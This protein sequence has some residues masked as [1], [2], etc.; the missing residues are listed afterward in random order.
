MVYRTER[1]RPM[2][3]TE[4]L[5]QKVYSLIEDW[6]SDSKSKSR[7]AE[8]ELISICEPIVK[9]FYKIAEQFGD[10]KVVGSFPYEY[11]VDRG[12]FFEVTDFTGN[13]I[14]FHYRDSCLGEY[15]E[16]YLEMPLYW[17]K[18]GADEEYFNECKER[19]VDK[20]ELELKKL[21]EDYPRKIEALEEKVR[22]AKEMQLTI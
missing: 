2:D 14:E 6:K 5:Q 18:D 16:D 10:P 13:H 12:E 19:A 3:K 4:I 15:Y 11:E 22:N 21:K 7:K 8:K 1:I 20:L 9:R 17:L